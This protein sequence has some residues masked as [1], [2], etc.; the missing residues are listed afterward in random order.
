[1]VCGVVQGVVADV[2]KA[3]C[4]IVLVDRNGHPGTSRALLGAAFNYGVQDPLAVLN[5]R[6]RKGRS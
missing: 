5:A 1:M 4:D 3:S 6:E 2:A